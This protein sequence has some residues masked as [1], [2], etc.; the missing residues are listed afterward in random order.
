MN[1]KKI[2]VILNA[3]FVLFVLTVTWLICPIGFETNDDTAIMSLVSGI[4]TGEPTCDT[5][6][7]GFFWGIILSSLYSLSDSIPWYVLIYMTLTWISMTIISCACFDICDNVHIELSGQKLKN[8]LPHILGGIIFCVLFIMLFCFS[9]VLFQFSVMP[10]ICGLGSIVL[11][12]LNPKGG[13]VFFVVSGLILFFSDIIRPNMGY[14]VSAAFAIAFIFL[15][16][17]KKQPDIMYPM[18]CATVQMLVYWVDNIYNKRVV[19]PSSDGFKHAMA[20]WKNYPHE[21]FADNPQLYESVGWTEKLYE[22]V[23]KWFFMDRR[24]NAEAFKKINSAKT[25]VKTGTD[26]STF[27]HKVLS[28]V[29]R[30]EHATE[31]IIGAI[32]ILTV[33]MALMIF[34]SLKKKR[35]FDLLILMASLAIT[36]GILLYFQFN[37]RLPY[38]VAFPVVILFFLP[39]IFIIGETISF[40]ISIDKPIPLFVFTVATGIIILFSVVSTKGLANITYIDSHERQGTNRIKKE[41]EQYA[42]EHIDNIYVYGSNMEYEGDPF[43]VYPDRKPYNLICWDAGY[44]LPRFYDRLRLNGLKE[45]Y[46]DG[47]LNDNVYILGEGEPDALLVSY[48]YEEFPGTKVK[49]TDSRDGF[50]VY[51]F[52]Q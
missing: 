20:V 2:N 34:I 12:Q 23:S 18:I 13:H 33:I 48:M 5:A 9:A 8:I 38:R 29:M 50:V 16:L 52:F 19:R 51:K 10:A 32:I 35:I 1:N 14:L 30:L 15:V 27:L 6:F 3:V 28:S 4:Y 11:M 41:I 22:L 45:L 49:I 44:Y 7:C 37:D 26:I 47:F 46:S 36:I 24:V 17:K 21:S 43:T 40:D 25:T 39:A 42:L 31:R